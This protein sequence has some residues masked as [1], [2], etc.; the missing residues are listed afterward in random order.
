MKFIYFVHSHKYSRSNNEQL[1][2]EYGITC[3]GVSYICNQDGIRM[4]AL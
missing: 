3:I 4:H 2:K 1:M